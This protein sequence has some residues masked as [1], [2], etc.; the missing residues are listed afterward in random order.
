MYG[1]HVHRAVLEAYQRQE[2]ASSAVTVH[3]VTEEFDEGPMIMTEL[4]PVLPSDTVETLEARVKE[5]EHSLYPRAVN[6]VLEKK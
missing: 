4:V 3:F 1:K 6:A 5:C 2:M